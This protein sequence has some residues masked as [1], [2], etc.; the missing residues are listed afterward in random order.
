M[1]RGKACRS[2]I[3][4]AKERHSLVNPKSHTIRNGLVQLS[5][6]IEDTS[7]CE[8]QFSGGF[9]CKKCFNLVKRCVDLTNNLEEIKNTIVRILSPTLGHDEVV[10]IGIK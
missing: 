5:S 9:V 3:L 1:E 7:K 2:P 10:T 6:K 8:Q 4:D